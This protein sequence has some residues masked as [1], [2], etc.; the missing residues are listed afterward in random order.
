MIK[1]SKVLKIMCLRFFILLGF[2]YLHFLKIF[3][4]WLSFL[5]F[6]LTK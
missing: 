3:P 6:N 5:F 1:I 4:K 2:L